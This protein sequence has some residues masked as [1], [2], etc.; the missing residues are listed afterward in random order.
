M[1]SSSQCNEMESDYY[2]G[3]DVDTRL[4]YEAKISDVGEDPY[5][6]SCVEQKAAEDCTISE[7][8]DFSYPDLYTYLINLPGMLLS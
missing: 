8:P 5:L 3:L 1:G 7:L 2:R 4:R 6:I